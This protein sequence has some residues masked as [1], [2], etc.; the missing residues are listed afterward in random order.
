MIDNELRFRKKNCYDKTDDV[1]VHVQKLILVLFCSFETVWT[2]GKPVCLHK[3]LYFVLKKQFERNLIYFGLNYDD[4]NVNYIIT[5]VNGIK[6][7]ISP[8][9]ISDVYCGL[10]DS[11]KCKLNRL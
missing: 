10:P 9:S 8:F 5:D 1:H 7:N 11:Y 3:E 2:N 6:M 4:I